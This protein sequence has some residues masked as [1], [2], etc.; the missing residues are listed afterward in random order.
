MCHHLMPYL[1]RYQARKKSHCKA[2]DSHLPKQK[3]RGEKE[4][5]RNPPGGGE[6]NTAWPG[7]DFVL[8][9]GRVLDKLRDYSA[10]GELER[11]SNFFCLHG[12]YYYVLDDPRRKKIHYL[13]IYVPIRGGRENTRD[14][15][16]AADLGEGVWWMAGGRR[17]VMMTRPVR[18]V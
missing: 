10:H 6:A 16:R 15:V 2:H 9:F 1:R 14:S 11:G 5:K 7:L 18:L 8:S 4:A 17:G 12:D 3:R 13:I